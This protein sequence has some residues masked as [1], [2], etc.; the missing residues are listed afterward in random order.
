MENLA[1]ESEQDG[2]VMFK[3]QSNVSWT[4]VRPITGNISAFALLERLMT[5]K[6]PANFNKDINGDYVA[7]QLYDPDFKISFKATPIEGQSI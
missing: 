5:E 7:E 2:E 6:M 1:F 3:K 4:F